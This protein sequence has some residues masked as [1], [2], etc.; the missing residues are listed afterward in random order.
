MYGSAR[1]LSAIT[2]SFSTPAGDNPTVAM[3]EAAYR[4][5]GID[6][7]YLN[8]EVGADAL[9][10][11][12]RGARAMGWVGFNCSLPHKVAVIEHLDALATSAEIIGA[13]NCVVRRE[14][15][16]IGENTDGQGFLASL[17]TVRDPAGCV[18]VVF[19]AGGAARAIAVEVALAGAAS[20]IVVNRDARRGRQ[21]AELIQTRTPAA[22]DAVSWDRP[23]RVPPG[24]GVVVNATSIGLSDPDA[25]IQLDPESLVTGTV[26]A[27]VIPNPPRTA[28][29]RDAR[30]RGCV[31]LDGLGMLVEQG[32]ISIRHW[33]GVDADSA[34]MRRA[35]EDALDVTPTIS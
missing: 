16:L 19:G 20:I 3:I 14:G 9:G 25:R 30:A 17:R 32:V 12:V 7:R 28:L 2:G 21:L 22:S 27:D 35:L 24:V 1:F 18:A 4:H 6:A 26:V 13:V 23:Y 11:A 10:D 29:I 33:T 15:R 34:V 31:V 5:H 8:C